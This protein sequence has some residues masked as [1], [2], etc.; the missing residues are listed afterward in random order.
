MSYGSGGNFNQ[1]GG[2]Q[3]NP[4]GAPQTP[5]YGPGPMPPG[6]VKNYLVES[7]ILLLCCGGVFAIPAIVYAAQVNGKLQSGDYQ[8]A[9][10]ASEN[11]KKWCLIALAIGVVCNLGMVVFYGIMIAA[12]GMQQ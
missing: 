1:G 11:A 10:A 2:Q 8:G 9:V 6:S 5:G 4:Y 7:I 3:G 12:G